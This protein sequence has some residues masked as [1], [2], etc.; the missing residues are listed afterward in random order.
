MYLMPPQARFEDWLLV[1]P[2]KS[3]RSISA[4]RAPAEASAAADTAPLIPPPTI[5]ASKRS[6]V[7]RSTFRARRRT[8]AP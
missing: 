3:L 8:A 7:S 1:K 5:R 6:A 4:T 2:A